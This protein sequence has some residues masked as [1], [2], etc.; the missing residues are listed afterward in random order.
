MSGTLKRRHTL[1]TH[2]VNE[3]EG[4]VSGDC[5]ADYV[6][7]ICTLRRRAIGSYRIATHTHTHT[8][9]HTCTNKLSKV[10]P[11]EKGLDGFVT[12]KGHRL[13]RQMNNNA[14]QMYK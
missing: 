7:A 13:L 10:T 4:W 11:K 6:A 3:W 14:V 5:A 9:T 1:S 12:C 2:L 8:H